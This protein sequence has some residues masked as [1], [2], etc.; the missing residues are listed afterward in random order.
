MDN[1]IGQTF[2]RLTVVKYAYNKNKH[3]FWLC[4][5]ACGKEVV[6]EQNKLKSGHTK[7]C[8]C[9]RIKDLTGQRFGRLTVVGLDSIR[10]KKSYWLCK[11]EC[12]N[13]CLVRSDLLQCN[14]TL[15]CGCY[16]KDRSLLPLPEYTEEVALKKA[17]S[18]LKGI[19]QRC[20]NSN[21]TKYSIYGGRGIIVCDR[22]KDKQTGL[23]SFLA[24]MG[25]PPSHKHQLD[26]IDNDG[27]YEPGNCRWVTNQQNNRNKQSDFDVTYKG[28]NKQ[29]GKWV[30]ELD[31]DFSTTKNRILC[32]WSV[33]EAFT[34]P[35]D[36]I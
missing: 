29:L 12:G 11:C 6:V 21:S 27:S 15:S 36:G 20:Y 35:A 30:E 8:G 28:E 18:I 22:W 13:E 16:V 25:V 14:N 32:G 26:R 5:C 3:N 4:R 17:K 10:N 23:A 7:S 9:L 1:L 33:E 24:D 2:N 31:L 19:K 34:T